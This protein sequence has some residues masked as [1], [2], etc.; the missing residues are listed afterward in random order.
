MCIRD[1]PCAARLCGSGIREEH[2]HAALADDMAGQRQVRIDLGDIFGIFVRSGGK[3]GVDRA[4]AQL[5]AGTDDTLQTRLRA[6]CDRG[7]AALQTGKTSC[8]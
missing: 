8:V 2:R 5:I 3:H 4:G 6:V 7:A 1:S